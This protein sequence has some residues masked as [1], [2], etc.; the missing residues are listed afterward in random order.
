METIIIQ[1]YLPAQGVSHELRLPKSL[2]CLM[3]A[4]IAARAL[5]PL[6]DGSYLPSHNSV[7][8]WQAT[9]ELLSMDKS[10]EQVGV[11]NGS[12]LLLL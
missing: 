7:F 1:V 2:N 5:A 6:S 9:G 3:A 11:V 4:N 8:A 12:K 10:L